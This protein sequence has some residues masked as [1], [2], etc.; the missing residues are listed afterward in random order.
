MNLLTNADAGAIPLVDGRVHTVITSPPYFNARDYG[1]PPTA[2]PPVTYTPMAGLEPVTVP[3][4]E[5]CLGLEPTPEAFTAHL[6]LCF[7]EVWRVLR[8]DGMVWLNLGDSYSQGGGAQV[9]QTKNA[10]HGLEGLRGKTPGLPAKQL[11]G[12][13]FRVAFALQAEGWWLRS[14][15]PWL[16]N[17][18]MPESVQDRPATAHE[19]WFLLAK[20]KTYFYDIEAVREPTL[21]DPRDKLWGKTK[22]TSR[23]GHEH[24][25]EMGMS[26]TR[27]QADGFVRMSNPAGRSRRTTDFW[28]ESLTALIKQQR[29]YLHHLERARDDGGFLLD[30]DGE[31]LGLMFNTA[32]YKGAHFATFPSH[33]VVPLVKCSISE[34]G[35]C[36]QCKKPWV[37]VVERIARNHKAREDR[38]IATGGAMSGGVGKNFPDVTLRTL[39]WHPACTCGFYPQPERG[40]VE[41]KRCEGTG[42]ERRYESAGGY[43]A[44][45]GRND[46]ANPGGGIMNYVPPET[47][48]PCP[49]CSGTGTVKGDIWPADVDDWETAPSIVLDPFAGTGTVGLALA[50]LQIANRYLAHFVGLDLNGEYLAD[51]ARGRLG[52][53]ALEEWE[54]GGDGRGDG[55]GL[56][57]LPLFAGLEE[58]K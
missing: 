15:S 19:T 46:P 4:M 33:L 25:L 23:H 34:R 2:W 22:T 29:C 37:R 31:P 39:A 12:I 32:S 10:S 49:A 6:V 13:P 16:K 28:Y 53:K 14:A 47:G 7:R 58:T 26:Q 43:S 54:A 24:D 44:G 8:A 40:E 45:A 17:N 41:C 9:L 18:A 51:L 52:L 38:Q 3:A 27:T 55:E 21:P 30:E 20:S 36:P 11:L 42:R 5:C 57:G 56:E 35:V 50:K 1:L 48:A